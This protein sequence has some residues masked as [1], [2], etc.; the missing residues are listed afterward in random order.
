MTI[1]IR[2]AIAED[3]ETLFSIRTSV[4]E[5]YQSRAELAQIGVTPE[6]VA[7][8]LKTVCRAW[9][10]EVDRQPVGFSMANAAEKTV[11]AL[12]ILPEYEGRG[13]GKQLLTVAEDWLWSMGCI[14]I[15]LLTGADLSLRAH[16]FYQH[17]GWQ[18]VGETSD[19]HIRYIKRSATTA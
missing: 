19:G 18:A 7:T 17:L 12:F 2:A 15:W 16:G 13:I 5:N 3:I 10:A 8:L 4:R 1:T 6:S 14:E 11:F 9:L